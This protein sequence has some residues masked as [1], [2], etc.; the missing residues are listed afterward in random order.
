[1][2]PNQI[3][4]TIKEHINPAMLLVIPA[5][6]SLGY[7]LKKTPKV[8]DWSIF[9]IITVAGIV[10]GIFVVGTSVDGAIQGILA[11]A[12]AIYGHQGFR[13]T[14]SAIKDEEGAT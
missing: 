5:L 3:I 13:Q 11:A 2:D 6:W 8:P 9:W 14:K 12:V 7:G 1:M 10:L 4:E